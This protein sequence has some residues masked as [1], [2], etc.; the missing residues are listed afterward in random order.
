MS[1][2]NIPNDILMH[3]FQFIK[4]YDPSISLTCKLWNELYM[5]VISKN[6][7]E[8]KVS[9]NIENIVS[10]FKYGIY[11]LFVNDCTIFHINNL[12]YSKSSLHNLSVIS[13]RYVSSLRGIDKFDKLQY[14]YVKSSSSFMIVE[15]L[16]CN[17]ID[18]TLINISFVDINLK[19]M[20][21]GLTNLEK[22]HLVNISNYKD[23]LTNMRDYKQ[24]YG[25]HN[26]ITKLTID[27]TVAFYMCQ[28]LFPKLEYLDVQRDTSLFNVDVYITP[29]I[30][31]HMITIHKL[32]DLWIYN[33]KIA[34]DEIHHLNSEKISQIII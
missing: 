2:N 28:I 15:K 6:K 11:S 22:L 12:L 18:L 27:T 30:I 24:I 33:Y 23:K 17:L 16:P 25:R 31:E 34:S 9:N 10:L 13:H 19:D 7:I 21:L 14:L 32:K 1:I 8:V 29:L 3:I 20:I 26:K 4:T 5:I